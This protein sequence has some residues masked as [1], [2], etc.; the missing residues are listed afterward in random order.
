[1]H[2]AYYLPCPA[3]VITSMYPSSKPRHY[4][5][6]FPKPLPLFAMLASRLS[7][8]FFAL[9]TSSVPKTRSQNALVTP[10]PFS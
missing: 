2:A 3:P 5:Y 8:F 4:M 10:K 1:M 9:G 7:H 6:V